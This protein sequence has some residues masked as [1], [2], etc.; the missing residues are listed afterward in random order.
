MKND[1][2]HLLMQCAIVIVFMI[3]ALLVLAYVVTHGQR[4]L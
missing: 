2:N 4:V 1:L 3:V